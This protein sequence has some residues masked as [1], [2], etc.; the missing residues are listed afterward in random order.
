MHLFTTKSECI[1]FSLGG[2]Q[3]SSNL[4]ELPVKFEAN[5]LTRAEDVLQKIGKNC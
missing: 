5:L 1:Q 4:K 2:E 3:H